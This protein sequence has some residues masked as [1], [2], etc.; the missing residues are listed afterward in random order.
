MTDEKDKRVSGGR[1]EYD[2]P[3][4]ALTA[5]IEANDWRLR[6]FFTGALIA[7]AIIGLATTAALLGFGIVLRDQQQT[8]D[9]L[10]ALVKQNNQFASDIQQQR[11]DFTRQTCEDT[12]HRHDN[13]TESFHKA[14]SAD[15]KNAKKLGLN[16]DEVRRREQVTQTIVDLL[17]PKQDCDKLVKQVLQPEPSPTPTPGP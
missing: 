11:V 3:N 10:K 15:I 12:N 9:Q 13:T 5:H 8:Q 6:R 16:P 14:A 2:D 1:R 17:Q 4:A 7:F